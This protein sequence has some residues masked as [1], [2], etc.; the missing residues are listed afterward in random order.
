MVGEAVGEDVL[1]SFFGGEGDEGEVLVVIRFGEGENL[2][3]TAI[4]VRFSH[5]VAEYVYGRVVAESF[6]FEV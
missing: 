5:E 2:Y 3:F 1:S 4:V 6:T